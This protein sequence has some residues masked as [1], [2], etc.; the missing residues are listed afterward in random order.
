MQQK[1]EMVL[2][3]KKNGLLKRREVRFI[4]QAE[5]NPGFENAKK[6][7]AEKFNCS[8]DVIVVNGVKGKFGRDTFLI[9]ALIYDSV[10]DKNKIEPK[11]KEK[12]GGSK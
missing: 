4:V 11:P 6:M 5:S 12:K 8:E 2:E 7:V 1:V 3:D 10:E 9:E